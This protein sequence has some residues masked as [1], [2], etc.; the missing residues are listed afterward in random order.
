MDM[1]KYIDGPDTL[2]RQGDVLLRRI[3]GL[4]DG[5]REK[6]NVVALGEATGHAHAMYGD[7]CVLI[8]DDTQFVDVRGEAFIVHTSDVSH[9]SNKS[10][11]DHREILIPP[12]Q[13]EVV[14]QREYD[15]AA[16][17]ERR[18]QD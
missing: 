3:S 5:V 1:H 8:S 4:P 6:D 17:L 2:F 11:A 10:D 12:G 15:Y 7:A 14:V 13:Y 9:M 16:E 18:V